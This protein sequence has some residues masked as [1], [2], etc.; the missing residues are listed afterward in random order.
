VVS[1]ALPVEAVLRTP[2]ELTLWAGETQ[3]GRVDKAPFRFS[4][5]TSKVADGLV[6]LSVR[7]GGK[8]V[9]SARV[10]VLNKGSEV[11]FKNGSSGKVVVPPT[12]YAHQHLRYHFDLAE[13]AREVLAILTWDQPGFD[14]ELA[15]GRGTCPHHGE[16]VAAEHGTGSPVIV[17]HRVAAEGATLPTGQWF[18]HVRLLNADKVL[19]QE[20]PFSVRAYVMR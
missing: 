15:L 16:Q 20:T 3:V 8:V 1:G 14:L 17:S 11:F 4:W 6:K 18:A 10:V 13:G 12:G 5:D 2:G 19:G 9:D 7:R